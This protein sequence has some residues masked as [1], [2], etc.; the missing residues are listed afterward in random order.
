MLQKIRRLRAGGQPRVIDLFAG[1]G[2]MSLGFQRAGCEIVAGLELEPIRARTHARN[3]HRHLGELAEAV[4]AAPRDVTALDPH[5]LLR[6]LGGDLFN[7]IDIIVGGPP[8]Q[9]YARVGR[10][11]LREI[12]QHPEAYLQDARGQLY[13]AYIRYVEALAPVAVVMENVPDILSYGGVNVGETVAESLEELGYE[14]RY[15]LLNAAY[16]GVPQTRER[17]YLIGIHR[18]AKTLP[19]FPKPTCHVDLP[20]GYRGTRSHA[21]AWINDCPAHAVPLAEPGRQLPHAVT[22]GDALSDLPVISDEEK[23]SLGRGSR[24]LTAR[25]AYHSKPRNEY[26]RLMR[27][28]PGFTGSDGVSSHVIRSLPRDYDLFRRMR[29]GDDYPAAWSLAQEMLREKA[30]ELRDRG[31]HVPEGGV[32]WEKLR[33]ELVPPYD[34][35]KFPNKWRKLER[36]FPSRTLMAHLSHD[37]YSHIHYDSAQARTISVRE[38]ARLQSFPDG[39]EYCGAMNAAFGQIGNAVPPLMAGALAGE[40]L[41][42]LRQARGSELVINTV[43]TA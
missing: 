9:A 22:C 34:P 29:P 38:A 2:G 43:R 1:C 12:A 40:L 41:R 21:I 39:F 23:L 15:T 13:A 25:R 31:I 26:Q 10:A 14:C 4:H 36:D 42:T 18:E 35:G 24:D 3:F 33:E 19:R 37:T 32:R 16:F 5:D 6:S 30:A 27:T 17:W 8:C 20:P 7:D 28:W 11:K